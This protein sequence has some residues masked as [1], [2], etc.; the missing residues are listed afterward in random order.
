VI[1]VAGLFDAARRI[2]PMQTG[3][4]QISSH[5]DAVSHLHANVDWNGAMITWPALNDR[6]LR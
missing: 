3:S 5:I 2:V 1:N 6:W 4:A